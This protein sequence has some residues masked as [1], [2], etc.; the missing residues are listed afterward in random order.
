MQQEQTKNA[1][2]IWYQASVV[3][4]ENRNNSHGICISRFI[5]NKWQERNCSSYVIIYSENSLDN[6]L[7]YFVCTNQF[8][9]KQL[10]IVIYRQYVIRKPSLFFIYHEAII[11]RIVFREIRKC[12]LRLI[13]FWK[14]YKMLQIMHSVNT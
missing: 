3:A 13:N 14:I 12:V 1:S 7:Y 5:L 2:Y 6:L 9:H 4:F 10:S 11:S 8:T